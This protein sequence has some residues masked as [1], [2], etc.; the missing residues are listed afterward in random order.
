M[1]IDKEQRQFKYRQDQKTGKQLCP[2]CQFKLESEDIFCPECGTRTQ[3]EEIECRV[4][5]TNNLS[6]EFCSDCGSNIIPKIC[7]NCNT[8]TYGDFCESCGV[9]VSDLGQIF[10]QNSA[11]IKEPES[12]S[13]EEA[14]DILNSFQARLTPETK[15]MQEKMRQ[16]IILQRER[17]IFQEREERIKNY[18]SSGIKKIDVIQTE[19]F[20]KIREQMKTFSGYI[21]RK[22]EEKE[23]EEERE[24]QR[25]QKIEEATR[26]EEARLR[27]MNR[28][29]GLWVS[30]LAR[31][32]I[33]LEIVNGAL[34]VSGKK[35]S[36]NYIYESIDI[37][38]VNWNGSNIEFYTIKTYIKW[39]AP[40]WELV[41]T[42]FN[43]RVSEDGEMMTGYMSSAE[44]WQEVFIK[45]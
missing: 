27:M 45:N 35:T 1:D 21:K 19:E 40:G 16:R 32:L 3:E 38:H 25:L 22:V 33:T 11:K 36:S 14:N 9:A 10:L 43:G 42:H 30:T 12:L 34:R 28:V 4:C 5:G 44:N 7:S 24:R 31:G 18:H 8:E 20:K 37:I 41:N 26:A 23:A 15:R 29:N 39:I 17:E 13:K 2:T 6:N